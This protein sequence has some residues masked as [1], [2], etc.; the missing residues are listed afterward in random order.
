MRVS[1]VEQMVHRWPKG[2]ENYRMYRIEYG[3]HA[4]SCVMVGSIWLP[5]DMSP[6]VIEAI[7]DPGEWV[8][9]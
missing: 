1:L 5:Q 9:R 4:E 6:D 8:D 7:L 3:G 2:M